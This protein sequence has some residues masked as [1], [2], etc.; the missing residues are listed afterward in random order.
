[1]WAA[2]EI[3]RKYGPDKRIVTVLPDS[4]RN[5]MTKFLDD[6]WMHENG[7]TDERWETNTLGDVLRS[8]PRREV[9]TTTS[10]DTVADAVMSMKDRGVSQ[11]PVLDEGRLVGIVTESDLLSRMVEGHANLSSAVA[12]VMFRNVETAHVSEDARVL[13]DLFAR[14]LVALVVDDEK[15]LLGILTKMDLVDHLTGKPDGVRE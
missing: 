9:I 15:H 11:L 1:M 5:Y 2:V 3:A 6:Q 14:D 12:E 8:M 7:F 13:T 10:A 4:V